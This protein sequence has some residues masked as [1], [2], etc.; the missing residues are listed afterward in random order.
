MA[1]DSLFQDIR[2][3]LRTLRRAPLFAAT[4]VATMGLGL[5]LVGSAFTLLNAYLLKPIDLPDPRALYALSWDTETTRRQRFSLADFEALQPEARRFAAVAAA[6]NVTFMQDAVSVGGLLVT[7]NYF[8]LLGARPALGR[9][10]RPDDAAA[11]G[12]RAVVVLSHNA[13]RSRYG[14]DP[15]HRR[16]TNPARTSAL[17]GRRCHG[18][19]FESGRPGAA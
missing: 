1:V 12:G 15:A 18:A 17:R 3:A 13:W 10:L 4:I 9:L 16:P 2:Y 7:G 11:R 8:E 5:G 6:K 14:S 19:A